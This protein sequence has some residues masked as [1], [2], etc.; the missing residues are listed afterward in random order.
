MRRTEPSLPLALA[1]RI[2]GILLQ[3][4]VGILR[5]QNRRKRGVK[6]FRHALLRSGVPQELT[7][8]LADAYY[9][10]GSPRQIMR[11]LDRLRKTPQGTR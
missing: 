7:G 1:A 10:A 9:R 11:Q 8:R 5:M 4:G 3:M 6:A 2:P